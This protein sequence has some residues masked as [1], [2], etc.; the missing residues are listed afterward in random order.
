MSDFELN[1]SHL[2]LKSLK[3]K[4]EIIK[5][6]ALNDPKLNNFTTA[7]KDLFNSLQNNNCDWKVND[8]FLLMNII[9]HGLTFTKKLKKMNS[10]KKK[11]LI[12]S[13][14]LNVLENE[15]KKN[16]DLIEIKE[17]IVDGIE[18]V[19]EPALELAMMTQNNEFKIPKNFVLS[20]LKVCK[21]GQN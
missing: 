19:V 1:V 11:K 6:I 20:L 2:N 9:Q 17:K 7:V 15:C 10:E 5:K 8:N 21:Q 18:T 3:G 14:I 13:L 4:K 16:E 12:L